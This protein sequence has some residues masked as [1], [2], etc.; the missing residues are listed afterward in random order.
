MLDQRTRQM[1]EE[2]EQARR[3]REQAEALHADYA[4]RLKQAEDEAR[5]MFEDS[6]RHAR[7]ERERLMA[8]WKAEMEKKKR[9]FYEDME[10]EK[11][12]AMREIQAQSADLVAMASEKVL[13]RKVDHRLAEEAVDELLHELQA[14]APGD[15]PPKDRRRRH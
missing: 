5:R 12:R 6:A 7:E 13:R 3:L 8:E 4:A 15:Q 14:G 11:R 9:E 1:Q 10:T 2:M